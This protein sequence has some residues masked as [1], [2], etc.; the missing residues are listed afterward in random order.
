MANDPY[1]KDVR[2]NPIA[3]DSFSLESTDISLFLFHVNPH[4]TPF[5]EHIS[6]STVQL[7]NFHEPQELQSSSFISTQAYSITKVEKIRR[8]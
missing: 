8:F 7:P 5:H 6:P 4:D 1:Y 3:L 2:V